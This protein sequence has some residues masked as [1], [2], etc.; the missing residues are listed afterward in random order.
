MGKHENSC[1]GVSSWRK[2]GIHSRAGQPMRCGWQ[3]ARVH[4]PVLTTTEAGGPSAP[5]TWAHTRTVYSVSGSRPSSSATVVS[6]ETSWDFSGPGSE[7]RGNSR[8]SQTLPSN[9]PTR[10]LRNPCSHSTQTCPPQPSKTFGPFSNSWSPPWPE[11]QE[12]LYPVA[13]GTLFQVMVTDELV[14]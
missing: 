10:P 11:C 6:P 2:S 4:L 7:D 5:A 12:T 8:T 1:N 14:A 13:P 9:A 3:L